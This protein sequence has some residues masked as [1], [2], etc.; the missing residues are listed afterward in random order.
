MDVG[1]VDWDNEHFLVNHQWTAVH[2]EGIAIS[3][4]RTMSACEELNNATPELHKWNW[5]VMTAASAAN[6]KERDM[7]ESKL[8]LK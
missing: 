8:M 6:V 1:K 4:E 5:G 7:R 3:Y 2:A